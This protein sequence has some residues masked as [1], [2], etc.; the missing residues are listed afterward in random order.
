[1]DS[2]RSFYDRI[3]RVYDL[4]ADRSEQEAREAG[5]A[6]LDVSAGEAVLEIGFG[7]GHALVALAEAVGKEGRVAG[8]DLSPGMRAVTEKRLGDAGLAEQ[9]ELV[10]GD[11]RT[12]PWKDDSFDA[13]FLCF[14]LELFE[15][16]DIPR[17]L[18]EV[19][20]VLRPGTGAAKGRLGLVS[21]TAGEHPGPVVEIY[22]WL[23]RHFP[24][25]VDCQPIDASGWLEGSGFEIETEQELSIWG[26]PVAV[27]TARPWAS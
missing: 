17:V 20:R 10:T 18:A 4:L 13:V 16:A 6:A 23:H 27:I 19:Q 7:T 1:M 25:F 21:R 26:L 9:V 14:T 15:P 12:L 8:I 22:R 2:T 24:H 11:A 3:S 5:L